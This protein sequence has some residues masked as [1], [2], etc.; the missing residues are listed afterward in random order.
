MP[1]FRVLYIDDSEESRKAEKILKEAGLD[2]QAIFIH[3]P[4]REE[5]NPPVLL[6]SE[7]LRPFD[8]LYLIEWYA[9]AY[10]K[11]A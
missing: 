5:K 7:G 4:V 10:G 6:A 9:H 3:D 1:R 11:K 8:T 2:Y